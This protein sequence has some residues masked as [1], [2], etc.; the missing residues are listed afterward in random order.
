MYKDS[1]NINISRDYK[2]IWDA[3]T[4]KWLIRIINKL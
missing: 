2:R 3:L 1:K 4:G